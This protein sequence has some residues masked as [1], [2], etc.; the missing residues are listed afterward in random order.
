M[1]LPDILGHTMPKRVILNG[2]FIPF[3]KKV[4]LDMILGVG[5]KEKTM[6]EQITGED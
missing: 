6:G 5:R 2:Y 3:Q 1:L 4:R